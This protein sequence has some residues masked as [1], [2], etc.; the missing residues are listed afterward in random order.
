MDSRPLRISPFV[1]DYSPVSSLFLGNLYMLPVHQHSKRT[2]H[3]LQWAEGNLP[4]TV[5]AYMG[6]HHKLMAR[7]L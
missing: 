3:D 7:H 5:I 1:L 4:S 2:R 6:S